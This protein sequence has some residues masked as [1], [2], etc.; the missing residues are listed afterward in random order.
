[1]SYVTDGRRVMGSW[2]RRELDYP[3]PLTNDYPDEHDHGGNVFWTC[4]SGDDCMGDPDGSRLAGIYWC[5]RCAIAKRDE[6]SLEHADSPAEKAR[7]AAIVSAPH[8][9]VA[10]S[11]LGG[12]PKRRRGLHE[13]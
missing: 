8:I 2:Y 10:T 13:R 1:M 6:R 12:L 7:W 3:V 9:P 11:S 4:R 5:H